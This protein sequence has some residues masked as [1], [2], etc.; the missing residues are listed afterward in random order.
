MEV[1]ENGEKGKTEKSCLHVKEPM[2]HETLQIQRLN[3]REERPAGQQ[4]VDNLT[5]GLLPFK[6]ESTAPFSR[7]LPARPTA[8]IHF[9]RRTSVEIH[10]IWIHLDAVD[11]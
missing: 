2:T 3:P 5:L 1:S 4:P 9:N 10:R 11:L 7:A 6:T 8:I